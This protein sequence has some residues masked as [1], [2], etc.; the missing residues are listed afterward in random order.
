MP[1]LNHVQT[2]LVPLLVSRSLYW[3]KFRF[4]R[5]LRQT[6]AIIFPFILLGNFVQAL[7]LSVFMPTGFFAQIYH[8]D[9]VIPA[10]NEISR[11]LM[12]IE[13]GTIN[14][15]AVA[16]V[17]FAAKFMAR[18]YLK[19]DN[20]AG[21]TGVTSFLMFNVNFTQGTNQDFFLFQNFGY[22]GMFFAFWLGVLIGWLFKFSKSPDQTGPSQFMSISELT[23]HSLRNM[24]LIFAII[25]VS[26][27]ISFGIN[28]ISPQGIIG[29]AYI[30]FRIPV[31]GLSGHVSIRLALVT[32]LNTI[33]WWAGIEGPL[34]ALN[35]F[36]SSP[37]ATANLN[38]ALEHHDLYHVPNPITINTVYYPFANF[39]GVGML[40]A[41]IIATLLIAKTKSARKIAGLSLFPSLVN[42][43]NPMLVGYPVI[44]NPI[45]LLPFAIIP[46]VT[47]AIAWTFIR[48]HL[49]PPVVY[50]VPSTTPGPLI[51]FLGTNGNW[52]AFFVSAL[53]LVVAVLIYLP[54]VWLSQT[55]NLE[56]IK[57]ERA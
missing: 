53:C 26:L 40:L 8:L 14:V 46:L 16:T 48:L 18:T 27:A 2:R 13:A 43:A 30:G 25:L 9:R 51:A 44:M 3:R 34:N 49:M 45:L 28:F 7:N 31:G 55:V 19:D 11:V 29:L 33:M 57:E 35:Q 5:T 22:R 4:Y 38:Y 12:L 41:L 42:I 36:G 1:M 17:Y 20:L 24:W 15:L 23:E 50:T 56:A 37:T 21:L 47:Q 6:L 10:Y 32:M 52:V 54:F 39:G